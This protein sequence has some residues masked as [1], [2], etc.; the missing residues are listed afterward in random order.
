VICPSEIIS[1]HPEYAGIVTMVVVLYW[2]VFVISSIGAG[3]GLKIVFI[4]YKPEDMGVKP[5]LIPFADRVE[6]NVLIL[7]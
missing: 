3:F 6:R 1:E 7:V 5:R 4:F 2:N